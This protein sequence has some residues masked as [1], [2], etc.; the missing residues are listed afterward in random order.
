MTRG[1]PR[2]ALLLLGVVL[3][4]VCVRQ[5]VDVH[6]PTVAASAPVQVVQ[7]PAPPQSAPRPAGDETVNTS[8]PDSA[9]LVSDSRKRPTLRMPR[10]TQRS[11]GAETSLLAPLI[12]VSRRLEGQTPEP[13][14]VD[15]TGM[16]LVLLTEPTSEDVQASAA[17]A[18][19]SC[20]RQDLQ[21]QAQGVTA[22]LAFVG[23]LLTGTERQDEQFSRVE[24]DALKI[25]VQWGNL[26][27]NHRQR[28]EL[29]T[30]DGSV[31]QSLSRQLTI[32][33]GVAPVATSVPVS[34]SWITRYGLYGS[35]C[36]DLFFD[37]DEKPVASGRV[38]ISG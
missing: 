28:L 9:A 8:R 19:E 6:G 30:P 11:V 22:D 33:D 36:V 14:D 4:A 15:H 10:S 37:Q 3:A 24:L 13:M 5:A 18:E 1:L 27:S 16:P 31:Y 17:G 35:W 25:V 26:F 12:G 34:G 23:V 7:A 38:V 21:V 32:T 20:K 29:M 2:R